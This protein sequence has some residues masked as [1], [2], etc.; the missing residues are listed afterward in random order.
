[1]AQNMTKPATAVTEQ[2]ILQL[3]TLARLR[4]SPAEVTTL[5]TELQHILSAMKMLD[6]V[7]TSSVVPMTHAIAMQL[8]LRADV[9]EP[10]LST[11][12]ALAAAPT[13]SNEHFVVPAAIGPHQ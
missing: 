1:M 8:R 6:S 10:S 11:T 5:C 12:T 2:E 3:A 9:V 7:D 13:K 4:F